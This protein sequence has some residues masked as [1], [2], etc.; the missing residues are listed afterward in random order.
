MT[1]TWRV[2]GNCSGKAGA[3]RSQVRPPSCH[4]EVSMA[5]QVSEEPFAFEAKDDCIGEEVNK[6]THLLS[7]DNMDCVHR[8]TEHEMPRL[9]VSAFQSFLKTGY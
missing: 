1:A 3:S 6:Y 4:R 8:R 7:V 9:S 2:A 5:W